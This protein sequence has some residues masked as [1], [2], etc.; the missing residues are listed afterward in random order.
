MREFLNTE[1]EEEKECESCGC[2]EGEEMLD[3]YML[4]MEDREITM[5]LCENCYESRLGDI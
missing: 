1:L 5:V 3:P 2:N 4:D